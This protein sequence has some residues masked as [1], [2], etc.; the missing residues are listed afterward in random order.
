MSHARERISQSHHYH[1]LILFRLRRAKSQINTVSRQVDINC[2]PQLIQ[3]AYSDAVSVPFGYLIIDL[4]MDTDER[5]RLLTNVFSVP[6]I[7]YF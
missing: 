6:T 7:A 1:E 3:T 5:L 2:Q 4:R